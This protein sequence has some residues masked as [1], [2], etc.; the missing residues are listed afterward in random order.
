M[1]SYY[2]NVGNTVRVYE[3]EPA[4]KKKPAA[5]VKKRRKVVFVY[6]NDHKHKIPATTVIT[7]MLIFAGACGTAAAFA[8]VSM[9]NKQ[10]AVL[11]DELHTIQSRNKELED[12]LKQNQFD[13]P[14]SLEEAA[15][16]KDMQYPKSYQIRHITVQEE[17]HAESN[18]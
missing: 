2:K 3:A 16:E 11:T 13:D 12:Q 4:V 10:A 7:L 9:A 6:K 14:V 18:K 8:N 5:K 15:R 17:N 1:A